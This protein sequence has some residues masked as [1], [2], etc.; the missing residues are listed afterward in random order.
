MT[1]NIGWVFDD[2]IQC[3]QEETTANTPP[4]TNISGVGAPTSTSMD[5]LTALNAS[6][7]SLV[8]DIKG[9]VD[10]MQI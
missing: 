1:T 8:K 7:A 2:D 5:A 9:S 4:V 6:L 3:E 10:S